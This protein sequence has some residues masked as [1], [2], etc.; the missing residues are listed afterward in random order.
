MGSLA[1]INGFIYAS[2]Y[3]LQI[4][5]SLLINDGKIEIIGNKDKILDYAKKEKIEILDL[6]NK[7]YAIP[8][9]IDAHIHIDELGEYING[10]DLR[11]VKSVK[12]LCESIKNKKDKFKNWIYGHGW[13]QEKF[14]ENR[15]PNHYDI[16]NCTKNK[17]AIF[18]RIDLHSALINEKAIKFLYSFDKEVYGIDKFPNNEPTGI[19][20]ETAFDEIRKLMRENRDIEEQKELIELAQNELISKGITSVGFMSVDEKSLSAILELR[21][22]NKLKIRISAF[23]NGNIMY[24]SKQI[25]NDD[26][27]QIKG[28]KLFSDGSLGSRTAY[29]S[30]PYEDDPENKG[31]IAME[32]DQLLENCLKAKELNLKTATHV[33]G[34]AA[35]DNVLD[36]YEK[37]GERN[38]IEHASLV[39]EDQFMKLSKINPIIVVQPHFIIS[40]FWVI[41]RLGINRAKW[42]YPFKS[43][44]NHGL[45]IAFSTDAPVEPIDPFLSIDAAVN[46]GSNQ[47][48][49]LSKYT[50]HESLNLQEAYASYTQK[51]ATAIY[52]QD[53]GSIELGKKGDIV[54]LSKDPLNSYLNNVVMTIIDGN[55]LYKN[56]FE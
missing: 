29:L 4:I 21:S 17:P 40:D 20:K 25:K 53:L 12:D 39:R 42:V 24:K 33:I 23:L 44:I 56:N 45:D 28:I 54:I 51:S 8:G 9:F 47:N 46:R 14:L 16:D 11:D 10:I 32:K 55:I 6:K 13:D 48:I 2:F 26:L 7:Y 37:C 27:F 49:E 18:S 50:M 1:I 5:N 19:I 15:W 30:Y 3:P 38:R 41:K 52:R 34:D 31:F 35:L 43:L 36:V 22:E